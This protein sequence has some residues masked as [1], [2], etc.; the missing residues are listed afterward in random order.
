MCKSRNMAL[1]DNE[2]MS[3]D[4]GIPRARGHRLTL[5]NKPLVSRLVLPLARF[6]NQDADV[7]GIRHGASVQSQAM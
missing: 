6:P 5:D 1:V 4:A 2:S 7:A 3:Q